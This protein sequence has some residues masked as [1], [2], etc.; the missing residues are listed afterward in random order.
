MIEELKQAGRGDILVVVGGVIPPQ[1]YEELF[2]AGAAGVYGPGSI[3]PLC[4]QKVLQALL[5]GVTRRSP[6]VAEDQER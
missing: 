1:D 5:T 2:A 4:A 3:I 6:H